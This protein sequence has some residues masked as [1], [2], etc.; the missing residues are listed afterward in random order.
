MFNFIFIFSF[1][2][3]NNHLAALINQTFNGNTT[4]QHITINEI[5]EK[6]RETVDAD[7]YRRVFTPKGFLLLP[8]IDEPGCYSNYAMDVSK[9]DLTKMHISKLVKVEVNNKPEAFIILC[10]LNSSQ[11]K[12]SK[13]KLDK[14]KQLVEHNEGFQFHVLIVDCKV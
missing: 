11:P 13:R 6:Y 8:N 10:S 7:Y 14:I 5:A 2:F 12:K 1:C 4:T 3:Q 9:L